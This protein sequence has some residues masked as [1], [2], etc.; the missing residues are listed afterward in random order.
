MDSKGRAQLHRAC[1]EVEEMFFLD[2]CCD[3]KLQKL[4]VCFVFWPAEG[5]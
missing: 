2:M 3:R 4:H 1:Q 5:L